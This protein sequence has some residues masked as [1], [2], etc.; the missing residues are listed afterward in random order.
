MELLKGY[1][2]ILRNDESVLH[3]F[4]GQKILIL[5]IRGEYCNYQITT[6]VFAGRVR[7]RSV[8]EVKREINRPYTKNKGRWIF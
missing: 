5:S 2:Y 3:Y 4:R 6:G 7:Q 8:A 1:Y